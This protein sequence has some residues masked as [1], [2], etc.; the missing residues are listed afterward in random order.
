M[1]ARL[2]LSLWSN[3]SQLK[4][5]SSTVAK[6]S[7]HRCMSGKEKSC[8]FT[9]S[10]RGCPVGSASSTHCNL[11]KHM[12]NRTWFRNIQTTAS[13]MLRHMYVL[14]KLTTQQRCLFLTKLTGTAQVKMCWTKARPTVCRF[15]IML[16][17][18]AAICCQIDVVMLWF[19]STFVSLHASCSAWSFKNRLV[20]IQSL[21]LSLP[22]C[23]LLFSSH[24]HSPHLS[25]LPN[26]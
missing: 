4:K 12:Q 17:V 20:Q 7:L 11:R 14:H 8:R 15:F 24:S 16:W 18:F 21:S 6:W 3:V 13:S 22:P 25:C 10:I 26:K 23:S 2:T 5:E 9:Q 1:L 19:C